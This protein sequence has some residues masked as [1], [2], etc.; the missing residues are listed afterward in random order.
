MPGPPA[1]PPAIIP[2]KFG[3]FFTCESA[4]MRISIGL[5]DCKSFILISPAATSTAVTVPA[6]VR[7][8]P[9]TAR[10]AVMRD[11]SSFL[12]PNTRNWSPFF[13]SFIVASLASENLIES[14]AYRL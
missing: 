7:N 4:L 11:A 5:P 10:S 9:N 2:A 1:P 3:I 14:G 13:R 8:E 12:S 6:T